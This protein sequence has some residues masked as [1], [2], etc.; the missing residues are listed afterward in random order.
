MTTPSV[1]IAQGILR[2]IQRDDPTLLKDCGA[3]SFGDLGIN[4]KRLG[5]V[6]FEVS[7][8][9]RLLHKVMI[10]VT[11]PNVYLVMLVLE[12][13]PERDIVLVDFK[14]CVGSELAKTL[15]EM[16]RP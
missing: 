5:G 7:I 9:K 8:T 16:T 1:H 10:E 3:C 15:D 12:T 2:Q 6:R 14:K 13:R 11:Q 4:R